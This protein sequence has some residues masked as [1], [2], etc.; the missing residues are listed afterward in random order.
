MA[1]AAI[2]NRIRSFASEIDLLRARPVERR[3]DANDP[4]ARRFDELKHDEI[5]D[6]EIRAPNSSGMSIACA[7]P[8]TDACAAK[9]RAVGPGRDGMQ[10][11]AQR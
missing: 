10:R 11:A 9:R 8:I 1:C 4:G 6:S 2:G 3:F 5:A 7:Y